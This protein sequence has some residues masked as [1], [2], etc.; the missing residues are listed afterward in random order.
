MKTGS[1][2]LAALNDG[3]HWILDGVAVDNVTTHAAF[4]NFTATAAGFFD[5]VGAS[6]NRERM[7]FASPTSGARVSRHWQLP[8]TRDGRWPPLRG[9]PAPRLKSCLRSPYGLPP[10]RLPAPHLRLPRSVQISS[11][12]P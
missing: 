1:R 12:L 2:H 9:R 5:A 10:K 4:R 8:T 6:E 11:V 3:R 7:S